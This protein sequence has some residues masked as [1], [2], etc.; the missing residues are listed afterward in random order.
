MGYTAEQ[1]ERYDAKL[2]QLKGFGLEGEASKQQAHWYAIGSEPPVLRLAPKGRVQSLMEE[3]LREHDAQFDWAP[4]LNLAELAKHEPA[5]PRFIVPDWLPCQ[6]ATLL[7][8]HGGIGKSGIALNLAVCIANGLMFFG[9]P[10]EQRRV[11]YLSCEDRENVLHWRLARICAYL[12]IDLASLADSL[13]LQDLVSEDVIL[14]ERNPQTGMTETPAF[15]RLRRRMA[16]TGAQVLIVDG[17]SDTFGGNENARGDVKRFVNSLVSLIPDDGAALLLGHVAKPAASGPITSEGYS[18]NTA[19]HNSVRAR[20]YLAPEIED[21]DDGRPAR[22][23]KLALELQKSNLGPTS[24]AMQFA[25]DEEAHLFVGKR[26]ATGGGV[27]D[28][29]RERA[30][31]TGILKAMQAAEAA[32]ISVPAAT[33]GQR[34]AFRVL[35]A[36]PA[37]PDS[38]RSGKPATRRFWRH[39]E[40]LRAIQHVADSSITRADRHKTLTIVL[41]PEGMRACGQ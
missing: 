8:G 23:G 21:N 39:V 10:V 6:Y 41:T 35:S 4:A 13:F 29:I 36:Q 11:L 26:E 18:G 5:A 24:A 38:L 34:T 25:W 27:I 17:V 16:A 30:E 14:W 3:D 28:S 37:F 32:G 7:A 31:Q 9:V 40:A 12:G 15:A 33:Q 1:Q 19:W 22:T 20:W 2:A